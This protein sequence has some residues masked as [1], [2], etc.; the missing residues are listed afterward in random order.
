MFQKAT[1]LTL[2]VFLI[3]FLC[4]QSFKDE[5]DKIVHAKEGQ[6][7]ATKKSLVIQ[8]KKS[9]GAP[10]ENK[11][12]KQICECQVNLLDRRYSFKRIKS[13]ERKYHKSGMYRLIEEDTL[14]KTQTTECMGSSKDLV[15]TSIPS[16]RQSFIDKCIQ[17][18]KL[19][20][21]KPLSDTLAA[22]FCSC[23]IDVLEKRKITLEKLD[24]LGDP[25]SFLYNEVA[26]KCG[27][28]FLEPSDFAKDW[29]VSNSKDIEGNVKVDSVAVISVMGMHKIKIAIGGQTRIWLIDSGASDLLISED[30]SKTLRQQGIISE[31][32][33]AGDGYY[34]LADNRLVVC[35]R[36]KIDNVH[37]GKF[38]INNVI[39]AVSNEAK[40]FLVGKSLLNKFSEWTLNNRNN[41][42]ILKK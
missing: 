4:A 29:T 21:P 1:L 22:A 15:L 16:Y 33:F 28:P 35:K 19:N 9:Y 24:D 8:C 20:S 27:S 5:N 42:L 39:L 2:S 37:I 36:Y 30:F 14:L 18:A 7:L 11:L 26:Y 25:S 12:I 23:A 40:E 6:P 17:K 10:V 31:M 32:D 13:Y 3:T 38:T 41:I 34:A